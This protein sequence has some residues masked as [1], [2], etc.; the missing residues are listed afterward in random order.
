MQPT[1]SAPA[2]A[3]GVGWEARLEEAVRLA[4]TDGHTVLALLN[5]RVLRLVLLGLLGLPYEQLLPGYSLTSQPVQKAL[6]AILSTGKKI[7][8][9]NV[10]V[11]LFV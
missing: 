5:K 4:V 1:S 9:H 8:L 7:F 2:P 3:L 6:A 11:R 10:A